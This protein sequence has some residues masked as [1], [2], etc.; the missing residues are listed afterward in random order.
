MKTRENGKRNSRELKQIGR[1]NTIAC[2]K[3][4]KARSLM[5]LAKDEVP[6]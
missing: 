5:D 6:S 3:R 4:R 2:G 1:R